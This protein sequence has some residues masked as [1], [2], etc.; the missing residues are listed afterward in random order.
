MGMP[1]KFSPEE[2]RKM[3]SQVRTLESQLTNEKDRGKRDALKKQ[4]QTL[5]FNITGR[6]M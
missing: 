3:E 2:I 1:S 4:I 5:K 6:H